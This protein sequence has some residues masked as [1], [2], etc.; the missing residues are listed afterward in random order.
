MFENTIIK[1]FSGAHRLRNYRGK[2][3]RLHGHNWKVKVTI[4]GNKLEEKTEILMDF[5]KL[6]KILNEILSKLDH[7]YLNEI[8]PFKKINPSSENIAIYIYEQLKNKI[9]NKSCKVFKVDVWENE[10]N[11]ASYF[12]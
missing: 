4:R 11:C 2:C 6:K 7:K 9:K 5:T 1:T 10:T 3:E 12:E 8:H